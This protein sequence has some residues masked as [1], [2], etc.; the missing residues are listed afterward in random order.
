MQ[1]AKYLARGCEAT[2][3]ARGVRGHSPGHFFVIENAKYV[4]SC[5]FHLYLTPMTLRK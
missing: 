2:E 3:I 1:D 5:P 4:I